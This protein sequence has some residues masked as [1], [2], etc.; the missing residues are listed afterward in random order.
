M[1]K[2]IYILAALACTGCANDDREQ[3]TPDL[4]LMFEPEMYMQVSHEDVDCFS[5]DEHFMVG[6]WKLPA[7]EVSWEKGKASAM[8]H[9]PPT[10]ASAREVFI[11]NTLK[12]ETLTDTLWLVNGQA[13][14]PETDEWLAFLAYSPAD[15]D[16]SC[17]K[18][19]GIIYQTD[20]LEDQ[21]DLLYTDPHID[22]RQA[23]NGWPV[24]LY[25]KHAL[26]K[27]NFRVKHRVA[28]DESITIKRITIDEVRHQ[29][30]FHSEHTP[31]WTMSET[32]APLTFFEGN[33]TTEP[34]PGS[35]GRY[36]M[37]IP[38][39]LDTQVT[40]EY[41]YA[42]FA[43]TSITQCLQTVPL[44]TRLEPGLSYTHTLSVGIDDVKFLQE[45]IQD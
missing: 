42:T 21:T 41:E 10:E 3:Y 26:C 31:Q 29:G 6:G 20:I 11:T 9:F 18:E 38:Q 34:L 33:Q 1:K 32:T 23:D 28:S 7:G 15:A 39:S 44:R 12:G 45:I 30:T 24:Q 8:P 37:V 16:C 17:T 27:V 2:Y 4:R 43:N 36:W 35:I 14:W 5:M 22:R 19:D 13:Q 40:V 25:F